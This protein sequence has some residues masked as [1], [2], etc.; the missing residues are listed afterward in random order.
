MT[1]HSLNE[2][3]YP[4]EERAITFTCFF[5]PYGRTSDRNPI[6]GIFKPTARAASLD[7][8]LGDRILSNVNELDLK[9]YALRPVTGYIKNNDKV[10]KKAK[11]SFIRISDNFKAIADTCY[12]DS[13]GMYN[14]Y[15]TPG[16][17]DITV[18]INNSSYTQKQEV[19]DGLT[20]T[21]MLFAKGAIKQ[22]FEDTTSFTN[23]DFLYVS[24]YLFDNAKRPIANAEVIVHDSSY[25]H[26]Y[27]RTN[28]YGKYAFSLLPGKYQVV[29]RSEKSNVKRTEIVLTPTSG[30]A[31]QLM[32]SN[33]F[34]KSAMLYL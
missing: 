33:L 14:M 3:L 32:Q 20:S 22:H 17:Y 19:G 27:V 11:V 1:I 23:S 2:D 8:Y 7:L 10:I 12:T 26:A 28:K 5:E 16:I 21:F 15:V 6:Y 34:S 25:I 9:R 18:T 13:S 4:T 24:N 31:S 29:V 30:F